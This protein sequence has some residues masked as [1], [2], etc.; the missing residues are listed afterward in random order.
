MTYIDLWDDTGAFHY[1]NMP[2]A[3]LD[4]FFTEE[5][6]IIQISFDLGKWWLAE[7]RVQGQASYD[8][9]QEAKAAG[10]AIVE[11]AE[12][13]LDAKLLEEAGLDPKT[14]RVRYDDGIR[15][16]E[17]DGDRWIDG[18]TRDGMA[19]RQ[20]WDAMKGDDLLSRGHATVQEALAAFTPVSDK[21][22]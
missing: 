13:A 19:G 15:F 4:A 14:W 11:E 18:D 5:R 16:E 6:E 22:A 12:T 9:L 10:D 7:D 20:R 2:E 21:A 8:T 1:R 17:I 3:G